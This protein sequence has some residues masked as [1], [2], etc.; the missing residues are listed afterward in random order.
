MEN[1]GIRQNTHT[2]INEVTVL[3]YIK[4]KEKEAILQKKNRRKR[5][6]VH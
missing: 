5:K 3:K 2:C 6:T 4:K 1:T